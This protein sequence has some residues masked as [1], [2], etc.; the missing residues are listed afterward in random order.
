M[1]ELPYAEDV[2]Y[3]KSGTSS[4]DAWIE[5]AKRQVES[6]GGKILME[7]FGKD[8]SERSAYM[9]AF[10]IEG[11]RFK[12]VWPVLPSKSRNEKAARIQAATMLYHDIKARCLTAVVMGTRSAFFSYLL[13]PDGRMATQADDDELTGLFSVRLLGRGNE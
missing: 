1:M 10:E 6:L 2:N 9:L 11:E 13:L 4:P 5:R 3:W 12:V 8:A 7:A